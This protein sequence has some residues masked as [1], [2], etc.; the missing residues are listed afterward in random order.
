MSHIHDP[1][2]PGNQEIQ[3]IQKI[4]MQMVEIQTET[5]WKTR[6]RDSIN[7]KQ[8]SNIIIKHIF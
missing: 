1:S 6:T 3:L 2:N 8:K 7:L 5:G 4:D